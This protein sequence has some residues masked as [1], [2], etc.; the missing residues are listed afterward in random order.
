MACCHSPNFMVPQVPNRK[1][2]QGERIAV[3]TVFPL[4]P[5]EPVSS[6]GVVFLCAYAIFWLVMLLRFVGGEMMSCVFSSL[7]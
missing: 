2:T 5:T 3:A 1:R 7:Q 4:K 6:V